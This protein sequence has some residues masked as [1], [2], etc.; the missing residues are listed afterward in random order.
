MEDNFAPQS[1]RLDA[2]VPDPR[3]NRG[4][5]SPAKPGYSSRSCTTPPLELQAC[6]ESFNRIK[7]LSARHILFFRLMAY[8]SIEPFPQSPTTLVIKAVHE[9]EIRRPVSVSR[10]MR[11]S[12]YQRGAK[13]AQ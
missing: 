8:K 13:A 10:T 1:F 3:K 5:I 12:G 7:V 11:R 4:G 2:R 6:P 9:P